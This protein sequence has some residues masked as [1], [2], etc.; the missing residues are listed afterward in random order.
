MDPH[1]PPASHPASPFPPAAKAASC[2]AQPAYPSA[3]HAPAATHTGSN[4]SAPPS[5]RSSF[6]SFQGAYIGNMT[7]IFVVRLL[8]IS[9]M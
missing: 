6:A 8:A 9:A 7:L 5:H 4:R 2:P 1:T 3:S